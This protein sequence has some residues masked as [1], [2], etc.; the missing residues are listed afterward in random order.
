MTAVCGLVVAGDRYTL[1]NLFPG[2]SCQARSA[3]YPVVTQHKEGKLLVGLKCHCITT[4][5]TQTVAAH[6]VCL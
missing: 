5:L 2:K 1:R 3:E 4:T 6:K